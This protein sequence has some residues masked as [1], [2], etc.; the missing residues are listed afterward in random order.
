MKKQQKR[1]LSSLREKKRYVAFE[2]IAETKIASSKIKEIVINSFKN[3]YG[4]LGL[5]KA[6]INFVEIRGDKGV[7]K[8][9]NNYVDE[10]RASFTMVGK[11]NKEDIL[12][13][14]LKVSGTLKKIKPEALIGGES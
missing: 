3:L 14:S 4:E 5:S 12:L 8:I 6:G 9:N 11:V 1:L 7:L 10:L 13:R 2:A